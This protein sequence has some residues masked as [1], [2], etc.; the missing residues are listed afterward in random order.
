VFRRDCRDPVHCAT[1]LGRR[2]SRRD[3]AGHGL[4]LSIAVN[5]FGG[6]S[7]AHVNP[8]VTMG[9]LVTGRIKPGLAMSTWSRKMLAPRSPR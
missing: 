7:G 1:C 3:R 9:M 4:A 6:I 5:N 2:R 8:A